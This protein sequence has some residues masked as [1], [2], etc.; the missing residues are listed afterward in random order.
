[1]CST[2]AR[3]SASLA[4]G[5]APFGG[6]APLPFMTDAV[7]ASIPRLK[8]GAHAALSPSFGA[9][10]TPAAWQTLHPDA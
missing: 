3:S 5:T 8:R 9:P 2:A 4:V 10:A 6:I 1:M 7:K